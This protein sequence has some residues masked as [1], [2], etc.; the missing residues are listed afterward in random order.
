[1]KKSKTALIREIMKLNPS[2]QRMGQDIS[3]LPYERLLEI[4]DQLIKSG[5]A[6]IERV[7]IRFGAEE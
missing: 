4:R 5:A 7:N 1:M 6:D 3:D 2:I